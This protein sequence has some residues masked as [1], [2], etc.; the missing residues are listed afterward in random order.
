MY[1]TLIFA[2]GFG[3]LDRYFWM[4]IGAVVLTSIVIAIVSAIWTARS[5]RRRLEE[6]RKHYAERGVPFQAE[7]AIGDVFH[8]A[9]LFQNHRVQITQLSRATYDGVEAEVYELSYESTTSNGDGGTE[10]R[11]I[12]QTVASLPI[13]PHDGLRFTVAPLHGWSGKLARLLGLT[14]KIDS[15]RH[16]TAYDRESVDWFNQAYAVSQID[17]A[18]Q[19]RIEQLLDVS[20]LNWLKT[21]KHLA[22]E[23]AE[24]RLLVWIPETVA[25]PAARESL[26]NDAVA[27]MRKLAAH[28]S[29]DS[30]AIVVQ[31]PTMS[32]AHNLVIYLAISGFGSWGVAVVFSVC[33][34]LIIGLSGLIEQAPGPIM[35]GLM[36]AT[37]L[38]WG[39]SAVF[40][41]KWLMRRSHSV[42]G[43]NLHDPAAVGRATDAAELSAA[44]EEAARRRMRKM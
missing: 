42:A 28:K 9:S 19:T 5:N 14:G 3:G 1:A 12:L 31:A 23:L 27:L 43:M 18:N 35:F 40:I 20:L 41:F 39:G 29:S 33:G 24:S 44:A 21:R 13:G 38:V 22:F 16:A 11:T 25:N 2:A 4:V 30:P 36:A 10:T 15:R 26:A 8:D 34:F 32:N 7:A 37:M 17:S 6:N